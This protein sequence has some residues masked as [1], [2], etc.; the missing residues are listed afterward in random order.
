MAQWLA[1]TAYFVYIGSMYLTVSTSTHATLVRKK[2]IFCLFMTDIQP[3]EEG[4]PLQY[5]GQ[6]PTCAASHLR[7]VGVRSRVP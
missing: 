6:L 5:H 7:G 4:I 3:G 2:R 1:Y